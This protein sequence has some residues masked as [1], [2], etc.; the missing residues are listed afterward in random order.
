MG[1]SSSHPMLNFNNNGSSPRNIFTSSST[2]SYSSSY[3]ND[4]CTQTTDS[5]GR[6]ETKRHKLK[7]LKINFNNVPTKLNKLGFLSQ[8]KR[9]NLTANAVATEQK[10]T[11]VN[12]SFKA[13]ASN[14]GSF[15]SL[16]SNFHY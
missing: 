10:A 7:S 4:K 1:A 15:A 6:S 8:K 14:Q 3:A 9:S 13:K 11:K 5:I 16:F 2:R 12:K